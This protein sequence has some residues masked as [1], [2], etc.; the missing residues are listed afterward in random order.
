ME[1]K[2]RK[3][4]S[5]TNR[6]CKVADPWLFYHNGY[7]YLTYTGYKKTCVKKAKTLTELKT[8]EPTV[9]FEPEQGHMW[10]LNHWSPEIHYYSEED[11]GEDAGWYLLI[12]LDDG[13]NINHR[14]YVLKSLNGEPDGQYGNPIT[15]EPN[16]PE[17]I[18]GIDD[19]T[20]NEGW[21]VGIT[22][23]RCNGSVYAMWVGE[24]G[25]QTDN[26]YQFI[27]LAKM[28]KPWL[29]SGKPG[30]I[31]TPTEKWEMGGAGPTASGKILPKVVEGGTPVYADDGRIYIIYTGSGYWS[32]YYAMGQLTYLGGDPTDINSWEKKKDPIFSMS[33]EICGCGHASYTK[34]PAGENIISYHAYIGQTTEG[35][36]YSFVDTYTVTDTGVII[37]DGSKKPRPD[38]AIMT[39]AIE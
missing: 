23:L 8:V 37:G 9:V 22:D 20:I 10:S 29:L 13:K 18:R 27:A 33:D 25:R 17:K 15:G 14:M 39:F 28:E 30:I 31:C 5:L 7:Y 35:G 32:K 11:F 19:P 34:S 38:G 26:F 1:N 3:Y 4:E 6:L 24:R 16:V 36:R 12:A 2:E 21:S